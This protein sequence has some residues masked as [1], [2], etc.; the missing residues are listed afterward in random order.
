MDTFNII[1][2]VP[3]AMEL[4]KLHVNFVKEKVKLNAISNWQWHGN[5]I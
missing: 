2:D 4:E 1:L 3:I 5:F